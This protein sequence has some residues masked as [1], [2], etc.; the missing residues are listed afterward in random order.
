MVRLVAQDSFRF[1]F[2][3]TRC[4]E[5]P[6]CLPALKT[7][8]YHALLSL[9]HHRRECVI[10]EPNRA[11]HENRESIAA[12][13]GQYK[14]RRSAFWRG[15]SRREVKRRRLF[16]AISPPPDIQQSLVD[17]DPNIRVV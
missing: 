13:A 6:E 9:F 8:T 17:L 4:P 16:V 10:S 14:R 15:S 1:H 11:C 3:R 12:V 7:G 5:N 2:G